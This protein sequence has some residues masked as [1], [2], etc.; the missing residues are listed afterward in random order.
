MIKKIIN[1]IKNMFKCERQ[2]PHLEMYEEIRPD[3]TEK[4]RK[5]Y[6]GNSE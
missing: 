4:I 5:K 3:K 1:F 6:K 2:D